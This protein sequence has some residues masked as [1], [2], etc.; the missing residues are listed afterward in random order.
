MM[1]RKAAILFA[2]DKRSAFDKLRDELAGIDQKHHAPAR[3]RQAARDHNTAS[4]QL[5]E[6][7]RRD[8]LSRQSIA[9]LRTLLD[10]DQPIPDELREAL[11]SAVPSIGVNK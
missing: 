5:D 9:Q 11:D 4:A 1:H 3:K 10:S 2:P 7:M 8:L 6:A